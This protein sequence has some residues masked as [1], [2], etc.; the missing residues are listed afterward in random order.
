LYVAS[1][2]QHNQQN[3]LK[4]YGLTSQQY[5]ILRILRGQSTNKASINLLKERMID[6]MSDVS[7]MID[8][9]VKM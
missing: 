2:I 7:R 9:M 4:E 3:F 1:A 6:K 5:N 8:R